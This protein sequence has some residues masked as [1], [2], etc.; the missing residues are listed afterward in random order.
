[1]YGPPLCRWE[2]STL[3]TA[4]V[5]GDVGLNL[6]SA[7]MRVPCRSGFRPSLVVD[8]LALDEAHVGLLPVLSPARHAAEASPL[9]RL[10]DDLHAV[11]FDIEHQLHRLFDVGLGGIAPHTEGVL[12]VV[13]HRQGGLL[14]HVRRDQHIHELLTIHCRRSSSS[15]T[16]PRVI[17]TLS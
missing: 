14:R 15:F 10:V 8:R 17:R 3:T 11:H 16:A 9:A 13:L 4:R 7:M 2:R 6:M 1:M 12:V 5:P